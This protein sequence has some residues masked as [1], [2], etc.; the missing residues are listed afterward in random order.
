MFYIFFSVIPSCVSK[1]Q[2]TEYPSM[3]NPF[4]GDGKLS[5]WYDPAMSTRSGLFYYTV[6]LLTPSLTH[7]AQTSSSKSV[8]PDVIR[9]LLDQNRDGATKQQHNFLLIPAC[10][11][12]RGCIQQKW[13]LARHA[14]AEIWTLRRCT[15]KKMVC[16]DGEGL[17]SNPIYAKLYERISHH[18]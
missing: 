3:W 15:Q 17:I 12:L 10:N 14:L 16:V 5:R 7:V 8:V 4:T 18:E 9:L 2:G 6:I 13:Q 11:G 1:T